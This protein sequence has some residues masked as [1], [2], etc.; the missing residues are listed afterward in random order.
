[1][2]GK[3]EKLTISIDE[4]EKEALEAYASSRNDS[5]SKVLRALARHFLYE[6]GHLNE[7]SKPLEGE[8]W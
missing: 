4:E 3:L 2:M 1:M 7:D 5:M 6:R 8:F